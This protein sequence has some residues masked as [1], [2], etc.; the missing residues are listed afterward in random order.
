MA[1]MLMRGK[2]EVRVAEQKCKVAKLVGTL[3]VTS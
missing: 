3:L 1:D 2:D